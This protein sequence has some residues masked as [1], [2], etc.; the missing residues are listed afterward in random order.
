MCLHTKYCVLSLN[1]WMTPNN[2]REKHFRNSLLAICAAAAGSAGL[3]RAGLPERALNQRS[4]IHSADSEVI[5]LTNCE[6]MYQA[7]VSK[8]ADNTIPSGVLCARTCIV[9]TTTCSYLPELPALQRTLVLVLSYGQLFW[10]ACFPDACT[11]VKTLAAAEYP[12]LHSSWATLSW[13]CHHY[14][15]CCHAVLAEVMTVLQLGKR[16][17]SVAYIVHI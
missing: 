3:T 15:W 14:C 17:S 5:P 8:R 11:I 4:R 2:T 7:A 12:G 16:V 13:Y 9:A 10:F 6:A 1:N